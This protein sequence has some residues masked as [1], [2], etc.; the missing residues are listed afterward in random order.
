M[1]LDQSA[2]AYNA[3]NNSWNTTTLGTSN[4]TGVGNDLNNNITGGTGNNSL[5][6]GAGSDTLIGNSGNDYLIGGDATTG[7]TS[8]RNIVSLGGSAGVSYT[9]AG[10]AIL[11]GTSVN[12]YSLTNASG[13]AAHQIIYAA[14][15]AYGTSG[16]QYQETMYVKANSTNSA[17]YVQLGIANSPFL[18]WLNIDLQSNAS[19]SGT[20]GSS[21]VVNNGPLAYVPSVSS[22]PSLNGLSYSV[23]YDSSSGWY[24]VTFNTLIESASNNIYPY[25]MS[26]DQTNTQSYQ[27]GTTFNSIGNSILFYQAG[28]GPADLADSLYGGAGS[29]TLIGGAGN[30][31]MDGGGG[32][33]DVASYSYVTPDMTLN[34]A[35]FN[36]SSY[37]TVSISADDVDL[38]RN[39]EGLISGLGNDLLTGDANANY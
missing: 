21:A 8:T 4:F 10:N 25:I 38:V 36:T 7:T 2:S 31:T 24:K 11:G 22:N 12:Y 19:A 30:D 1:Y 6:G 37:Q 3:A 17:R 5:V 14:N 35:S 18:T 34:L 39:F 26:L 20:F 16:Y 23:I 13:S 29:D 27:Y 33:V 9:T 28:F 15:S 32:G